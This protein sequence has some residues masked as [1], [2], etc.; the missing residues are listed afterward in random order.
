MKKVILLLI[1]LW[2]GL[3]A[4]SNSVKANTNEYNAAVIAHILQTKLN[5]TNVDTE[6]LMKSELDKLGHKFALETLS[7]IQVYL[8]SIIDGVMAEMRLKIDEEYKCQLL[9]GSEIQGKECK[10]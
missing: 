7:I 1:V 9:K 8:P 6:A 10:E 3:T 4:F 2:F 5:G